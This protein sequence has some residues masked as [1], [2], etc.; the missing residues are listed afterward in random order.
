MKVQSLCLNT[1]AVAVVLSCAL[2]L[3]GA[4]PSGWVM[5]GKPTDYEAALDPSTTYNGHLSAYVKA[6]DAYTSAGFGTLMQDFKAERY[7][8]K[9]VRLRAYVKTAD[10]RGWAGLW[11]RIDKGSTP[12]AFDNMQDRPIRGTTE[13]KQYEVVL[14]VPNDASII[15][16][17]LLQSG[18]GTAWIS[19]ATFE[20][21]GKDV[22]T[23]V[24]SKPEEPVNLSFEK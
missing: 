5:G 20:V 24:P 12:A 2:A 8:G 18:Q 9:R 3:Q 6:K 11:M 22:A 14:D 1:V 4:M 19:Q 15:A 7:L 21:V 23:T 10:V 16:F 13:W 17:G